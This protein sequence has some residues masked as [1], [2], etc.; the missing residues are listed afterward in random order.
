MRLPGDLCGSSKTVFEKSTVFRRHSV[1]FRRPENRLFSDRE[2]G[3]LTNGVFR[4]D[5]SGVYEAILLVILCG[6][7]KTIFEK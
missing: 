4:V 1:I 5:D 2:L 3:H 7:S 6:A